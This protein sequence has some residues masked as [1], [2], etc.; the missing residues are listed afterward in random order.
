MGHSWFLH[1]SIMGQP[2]EMGRYARNFPR[3]SRAGQNV[4]AAKG[5]NQ[6][7]PDF[8]PEIMFFVQNAHTRLCEYRIE[9]RRIFT[10][11]VYYLFILFK[12]F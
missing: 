3:F 4:G 6:L 9:F 8:Q 5:Q 10:S 11:F 12:P 1:G 2:G 7:R